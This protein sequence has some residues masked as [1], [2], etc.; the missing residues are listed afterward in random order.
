[1]S[2]RGFVA[3]LF[4]ITV[5]TSVTAAQEP[6]DGGIFRWNNGRWVQVDGFGIRIAVAPDGEPWVVNSR[7]EIYRSVNGVFEKLPGS[8]KD[9]A[10][11][12]DGGA[13]VIGTDD[14]VY[15][16]NGSDWDRVQGSGVAISADRSGAPW[17]VNAS[18]E[19][20]QWNGQRFI[21]RLAVAA[22]ASAL[23]QRDRRG[24]SM[25]AVKSSGGKATGSGG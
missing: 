23:E 4:A 25:S 7:N 6:S 24:W 9:I 16:W 3:A 21:G 14:G 20:Y 15:R 5:M 10:I 17:V 18:G 12:G 19:I 1:M 11:G 22:C 2:A 13:W 8:A